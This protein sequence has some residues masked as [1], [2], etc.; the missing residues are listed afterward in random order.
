M[1]KDVAEL[2]PHRSAFVLVALICVLLLSA[3]SGA[4][5]RVT[6]P[7]IN[8]A[9]SGGGAADTYRIALSNLLVNNSTSRGGTGD[10]YVI[11]SL[12]FASGATQY[13]DRGYTIG[14]PVPSAVSGQTYIEAANGDKGADAGS[15]SFMSFS[16]NRNVIIYVAHD[17]QIASK[18]TWLTANFLDTGTQVYGSSGGTEPF[19]LYENIYPAN[20]AITLGSNIPS[21]WN[22]RNSSMYT[23]VAAP[24]RHSTTPPTAPSSVHQICASAAVVGLQWTGS[25]DRVGVFAYRISRNGMVIA[26]VSYA[27]T[28]YSDITVSASTRYRYVVTAVDAAGLSTDSRP[29]EVT[30]APDS[31]DGDAAYCPSSKI[32]SM[33]FDYSGAFTETSGHTSDRP[34]YT[35]GSDLWGVTWGQDGNTYLTFGDGWGLCGEEDTG[36]EAGND[37]TSLGFAVISGPPPFSGCP[38]QFANIYGGHNSSHP[39]DGKDPGNPVLLGLT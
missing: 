25:A 27:Q 29:V 8:D 17:T 12:A 36:S 16:A 28:G 23:V 13:V 21:G 2:P 33:T 37:Y 7:T 35:D 11:D 32:T 5:S 14:P 19:E 31:A 30:T 38:S 20:T 34:P 9:P 3:P 4:A 15:A 18:P 26:T 22:P 39:Y 1:A 24:A 10:G 6:N